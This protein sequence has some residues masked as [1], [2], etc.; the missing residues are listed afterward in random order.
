MQVH[1]AVPLNAFAKIRQSVNDS[2]IVRHGQANLE[3][4]IV[5]WSVGSGS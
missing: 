2:K 4:T 1:N 3:A 5:G